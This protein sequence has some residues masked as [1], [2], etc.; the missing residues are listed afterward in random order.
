MCCRP[1]NLQDIK[2]EAIPMLKAFCATQRHR[3]N[4][5]SWYCDRKCPY[6]EE[7]AMYEWEPPAEQC[8]L[9]RFVKATNARKDPED[10]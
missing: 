2:E 9:D 5:G 3:A 10:I 4:D 6:Y 8:A 7:P 1:P